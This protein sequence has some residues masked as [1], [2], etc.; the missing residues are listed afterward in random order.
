MLF[1]SEEALQKLAEPPAV[2]NPT[3]VEYALKKQGL[4]PEEWKEILAAPPKYFT[5][6]PTYYPFLRSVKY[7][8]KILGRLNILP[9][10]TYE[11][12]FEL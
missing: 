3:I 1:R 6:Y 8:I 11:K 5:D 9:P 7:I 12:Y 4:S 10:Y 2:E